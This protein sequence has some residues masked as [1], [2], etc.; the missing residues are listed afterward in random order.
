MDLRIVD[1]KGAPLAGLSSADLRVSV[2]GRP[3]A[4]E[5]LRWVSGSTA[6]AEGLP[7]EQAQQAGVPAAPPGRLVAFLF[8][9]DLSQASRVAGLMQMKQRA[10]KLLAS[11]EEQDR[12]AVLS[13]D[14]HLKL[15]TDFTSDRGRVRGIVE[16]SILLEEPPARLPASAFPSLLASFDGAAARAAA[17]PEAALLVVANALAPLPGTKSL[18]FFGWGMGQL[19]GDTVQLRPEYQ[20]ARRALTRGR[21]VV[22]AL[23]V[24]E[25]DFH[26]LEMGL[27][28]VADDTGG[29][30]VKTHLF[31]ELAM[32]RLERALAGYYA[33]SFEKPPLPPGRHQV[34]VELVGR[35]GTVLTTATYT[36]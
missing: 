17:S 1:D 21:I 20:A 8:Q 35:K 18:V 32:D 27:E 30:Y 9:K 13:F 34:Q 4:I 36:D 3:A 2:D 16:R 23:D 19:S 33:L 25:A 24:T 31:P 29:F 14:S 10:A 7:P 6:Y 5:S 15:W 12:V 22:F 11:L 26:S 28:Q